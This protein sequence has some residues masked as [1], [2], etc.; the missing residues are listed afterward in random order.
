[1]NTDGAMTAAATPCSPT[2]SRFLSM[3]ARLCAYASART[4]FSYSTRF[5]A[6]ILAAITVFQTFYYPRETGQRLSS[7][8]RAVVSIFAVIV[9]YNLYAVGIAR[10]E[11]LLDFLQVLAAFKLYISI[12]KYVPQVRYFVIIRGPHVLTYLIVT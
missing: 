5:Q 9:F 10:Y 6:S 7:F 4:R 1:M 12:A 11:H 3:Y 2:M 8:N